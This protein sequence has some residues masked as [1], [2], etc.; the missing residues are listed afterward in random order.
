MIAPVCSV[1]SNTFPA[2]PSNKSH[3]AHYHGSVTVH[4][5]WHP[6]FGKALEVGYYQD[7]EN[8]ALLKCKTPDG[9]WMMVP[10]WMTDKQSCMSMKEVE[11]PNISIIALQNLSSLLKRLVLIR[12]GVNDFARR[13]NSIKG[14]DCE[15][16]SQ[17]RPSTGTAALRTTRPMGKS[18]QRRAGGNNRSGCRIASGLGKGE[19]RKQ[20]PARRSR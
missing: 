19:K 7:N 5:P 16:E 9:I 10:Q 6:L 12:D 17:N 15:Q 18:A 8:G 2:A 11:T 13:N 3:T 4:Y 20:C 1:L 14:G